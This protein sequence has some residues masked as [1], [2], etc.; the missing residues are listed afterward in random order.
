MSLVIVG[1]SHRTAPLPVL[2][3]L[4]IPPGE[5]D[6]LL[7]QLRVVAPPCF[8]LSTCNR[9]E[10]CATTL[11]AADAFLHLL[12]DRAGI[13]VGD[14]RQYAYILEHE[15]AVTHLLR[16]ASGLDSMVLGEDHIQAQLKR[17]LAAAR[18]AEML[19]PTLERLGAIALG[20]GK[21]VRTFTGVGQH[22]VSLETLAVE[23][24]LAR[25][26][27]TGPH[28]VLVLGSGASAGIV[29][30]HLRARGVAV[31]VVGRSHHAA[32]TLADE[33]HAAWLPWEQLPEALVHA[34][35]VFSCTS[36]PHPVLT[37]ETLAR[38][39]DRRGAAPLLCVDIGM[40]RDVDA[41]V[42]TL[43]GMSVI[44]LEELAA[45][46]AQHRAERER[47]LPAAEAIVAREARR[48][49][50]WLQTRA[51][52]GEIVARRQR[53]EFLAE[54]ELKRALARLQTSSAHDRAVLAEL[55]RRLTRKLM[56]E[57]SR[58]DIAEPG[59]TLAEAAS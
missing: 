56:H 20:C 44:R 26:P 53:A 6:H 18:G 52:V 9:T 21:R 8:V 40:P 3:R 24:A 29:V 36:A 54:M 1:V 25:T 19:G 4:A 28:D 38:R 37:A 48:F 13:S 31:T 17:A 58:A 30:R 5:T 43:P 45:T 35:M 22:S 49:A 50:E 55:A 51:T 59:D 14:L 42:D 34:Q 23:E 27:V 10:I 33:S 11:H 16:V 39:V 46:A 7:A 41:A 15:Q 57:E 2:E 32:N 47:H 12:A